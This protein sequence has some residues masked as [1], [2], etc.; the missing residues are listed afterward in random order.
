MKRG[1]LIGLLLLVAAAPSAHAYVDPGTGSLLL[2]VLLGGLAGVLVAVK[3]L[4][5]RIGA[6]FGRKPSDARETPER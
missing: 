6:F 4:W 3:L 2:Q 5:H 1:L